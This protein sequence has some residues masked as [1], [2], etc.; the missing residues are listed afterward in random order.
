MASRRADDPQ[1][2]QKPLQVNVLQHLP[3]R[4]RPRPTPTRRDTSPT[5]RRASRG[6]TS[7][8]RK[9]RWRFW[10]QRP[11]ALSRTQTFTSSRHRRVS[12]PHQRLRCPGHNRQLALVRKRSSTSPD[13]KRLSPSGCSSPLHF[14]EPTTIPSRPAMV[15]EDHRRTARV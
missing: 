10:A 5:P 9:A 4:R 12:K 14:Q 3:R 7:G 13:F 8:A 2:L 15:Y 6:P 11:T 1:E